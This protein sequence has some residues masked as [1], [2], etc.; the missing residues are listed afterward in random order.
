MAD[1]Q[2]A[3]PAKTS[4][5]ETPWWGNKPWW[6]NL[7]L[8]LLS[9]TALSSG[10]LFMRNLLVE[11]QAGR[12]SLNWPQTEGVVTQCD[13]RK[14]GRDAHVRIS[15]EYMVGGKP[16]VS[17]QVNVAKD[18]ML[19]EPRAFADKHPVGTKIPVYY[20]RDRPEVSVVVPGVDS[21]NTA[22]LVLFGAMLLFLSSSSM[23]LLFQTVRA[24]RA[25]Q[26]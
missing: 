8:A 11:R 6:G 15:Y 9:I 19:S 14:S 21:E 25:N 1:R 7:I 12:E 10:G 18:Y 2:T 4:Q 26:I 17:A 16:Y 23:V 22:L 20:K 5:S 24:S 3:A 13:Y